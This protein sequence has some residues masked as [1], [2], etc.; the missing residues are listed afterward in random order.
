MSQRDGQL[1]EFA[2]CPNA[3]G[4]AHFDQIVLILSPASVRSDRR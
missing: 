3:F 1:R 2:G 4:F